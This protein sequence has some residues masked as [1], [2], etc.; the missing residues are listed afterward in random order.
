MP[1]RLSLFGPPRLLDSQGKLISVPAKTFVLIAYLLLGCRGNL[2][3]R[4][5]LRQYLWES[6][7]SRTAATN[8]RKLLERI[9]ERQAEDGFELIVSRRSH[10]ELAS[11]SVQ[12]DLARF[13]EILAAWP[14]SDLVELCDLYGGDLLEGFDGEESEFREWLQVQ[15]TK[16]RDAF[17]GAVAARIEPFDPGADRIPIRIAAR[18]LLEVDPYN[19]VA[20]R[21]LMRLHAEENELA[22]VRDVYR[23]LELRLREELGV[24]PDPATAELYRSLLP[25]RLPAATSRR[26]IPNAFELAIGAS[27][28]SVEPAAPGSET[29]DHLVTPSAAAP[30]RAGIP[31]I[32]VLPPLRLGAQDYHHH[33]AVSLIED[34]T[35]GLCRFKALSVIAP[36]TAWQLSLGGKKTAFKTFGIDYAVETQLQAHG[37]EHWL[38]VKLLNATTREILWTEQY[39][40]KRDQTAERYRDL[41]VAILRSLVDKIERTELARYEEVQEPTAYHL[42]LS[43]QRYL[44]KLDLP[45]VRRARRSFKSAMGSCPTFVP[46]ISGLARTYQLEWLL[47]ARGENE[48][49]VEAERLANRSIDIDP[50]DARGYREL[51]LCSAYS[52]R[53]DD[54]LEALAQ[55]E[56]CHPQYADLL[57]D[58]AEALVHACDPATA[59]QKITQAIELNPISPDTYW[60]TAGGAN[61]QLQRYADAIDCLSR[62]R[63]QSPAFRLL[64][65]SWA[66][67]GDSEQASEYVRKTREIHPDF[68]VSS[69]FSVMP[70]RDPKIVSAYEQG[71]REAGFN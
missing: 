56:R 68:H 66:M 39:L 5:V 69:F 57:S 42:Y 37:G 15:R 8:L 2:A 1:C 58:F 32:S 4:I 41:S 29:A 50:D 11:S 44:R 62:M 43:G 30:S 7:D 9:R 26:E 23:S 36:H 46:S 3:S 12:I 35:I 55:G 10:V 61:Y 51:G 49:L 59:L 53:F 67:L 19:E 18:R 16:L 24:E 14:S 6:A 64:A 17:I 27:A 65:A 31:R 33:L 40:F 21:A 22:R 45:N 52:G 71:L 13:A 47:L 20:H 28:A 25:A 63:D 60:W 54:S 38:S 48:L 34:V 70:F